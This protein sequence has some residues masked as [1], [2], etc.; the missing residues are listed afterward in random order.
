MCTLIL[1]F[2]PAETD[3]LFWMNRLFS[4]GT[5]LS[6]VFP[7]FLE[8]KLCNLAPETKE[9]PNPKPFPNLMHAHVHLLT[10]QRAREHPTGRSLEQKCLEITVACALL[11]SNKGMSTLG[12]GVSEAGSHQASRIRRKYQHHVRSEG[13]TTFRR[14]KKQKC[15]QAGERLTTLPTCKGAPASSRKNCSSAAV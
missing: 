15:F 11:M 1:D 3:T 2:M 10:E 12:R 4:Q 8:C 9:R 7:L 13:N 14:Q 5:F 6:S